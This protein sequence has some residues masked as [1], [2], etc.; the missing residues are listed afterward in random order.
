M[1][2]W[3]HKWLLILAVMLGVVIG[4]CEA[5]ATTEPAGSSPVLHAMP[6]SSNAEKK[7]PSANGTEAEEKMA[8]QNTTAAVQDLMPA[9]DPVTE[10]DG[11]DAAVPPYEPKSQLDP[12]MPL[13]Q[14]KPAEPSEIRK[15]DKPRRMLTPLEKM[16][17]SQ[18]KLVAVVMGE[19][20]KLAMVE[21]ATGKGYEVRIGT[22]MGKNEGQV[23]DI[24]SDRIIVR[25]IVTDFKGVV[26]E[27]FQ[28]LKLHK[29]DSGD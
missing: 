28:E 2:Y 23:V 11:L 27:R 20:L 17:L 13:I 18:I 3:A 21:E 26:T 14:E 12:F 24:Q 1:T 29:A 10:N 16:S 22:Y 4:V 5:T 25:E 15:P 9:G 7:L 6:R 8:A 19:D